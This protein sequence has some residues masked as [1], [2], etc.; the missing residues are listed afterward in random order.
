MLIILFKQNNWQQRG[1]VW[2]GAGGLK[3]HKP[4]YNYSLKPAAL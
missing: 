3:A 2:G 4:K 1:K